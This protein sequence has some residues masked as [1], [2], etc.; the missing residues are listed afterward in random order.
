L[1]SEHRTP[2][3]PEQTMILP[4]PMAE[5]PPLEAPAPDPEAA[6]AG[7]TDGD[8][9]PDD[10]AAPLP[11]L[12]WGQPPAPVGTDPSAPAAP[13]GPAD[14][15][16]PAAPEAPA[17]AASLPPTVTVQRGDSLCSITDDLLGPA[18]DGISEIAASWPQLHEAN[19]DLIGPDPDRLLPGQE[20]T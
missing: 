7:S 18:P 8:G 14:P 9:D 12:G 5:L 19:R 11:P 4:A 20:L 15:D 3:G 17:P 6:A 2:P 13:T 1:A 16:G 10:R